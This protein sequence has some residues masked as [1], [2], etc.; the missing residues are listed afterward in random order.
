[1]YQPLAREAVETKVLRVAQFCAIVGKEVHIVHGSTGY[2]YPVGF[3]A[4]SVANVLALPE[5]LPYKAV[6]AVQFHACFPS[7]TTHED[8]S[9]VTAVAANKPQLKHL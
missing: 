2:P 9:R 8:K 3:L 5:V 6:R 7:R 4:L 1:M